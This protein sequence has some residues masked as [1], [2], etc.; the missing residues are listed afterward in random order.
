[1]KNES[2]QATLQLEEDWAQLELSP[3]DTVRCL[4]KWKN[5]TFTAN[6]AYGLVIVHPDVLVS[7]T[8]VADA[9]NCLRKSVLQDRVRATSSLSKALFYGSALHS[10]LQTG[11]ANDFSDKTLRAEID[12]Q[13]VSNM[14]KLYL[15][16]LSCEEASTYLHD[17]LSL[18]QQW[19]HKFHGQLGAVEPMR[20]KNKMLPVSVS[21][22]RALDIEERFW[23]PIYGLK[24]NIDVTAE[25]KL[26]IDG[27]LETIAAPLEFK[28][29]KTEYQQSSYRAQVMLYTLMM[30]ERYNVDVSAGYLYYLESGQIT[31]VPAA[32]N[33][34]R[35][36]LITRNEVAMHMKKK[37]LPPMIKNDF[38]CKNCYASEACFTYQKT[39]DPDFDLPHLGEKEIAFFRKWET[40]ITKEE[41]EMFRYRNEL[42]HMTAEEREKVN[43]CFAGLKVVPD[44]ETFNAG[45]DRMNQW[46]YQL[47]RKEHMLDSQIGEREPII[48]SDLEGRYAIS[49]GFVVKIQGNVI[50]VNV[51]RPL[52]DSRSRLP[53]FNLSNQLFRGQIP[54]VNDIV[55]RVD[56]DE[57]K[58]GM[59]IVRN[60]LISLLLPS[61]SRNASVSTERLRDLIVNLVEPKFSKPTTAP[62]RS[63]QIALNLDQTAAKEKVM[64]AKDY[65][66]ILGMP[67]TGKTTTIANIIKSLVDAGQ[68]VLLTS[69]THSAVDTIILKLLKHDI[70]ILRLGGLGKINPEVAKH[71][72]TEN[73]N[74][75]TFEEL[76][77]H[78]NS[79]N[80][81]ATTCLSINH[82]I[83]EKRRFDYCI[84]DEASQ[85]T[86]PVCIGPLRFADKFVLVGDHYQLPPLVKHTEAREGGLDVSLFKILC[87]AHPSA[88]TYLSHQYRM[89]QDIM[90]ISNTLIY[91][92]RLA[93]G[94]EELKNRRLKLDIGK[95]AQLHPKSC[96][97]C[98]VGLA[99]DP[100][101]PVMYLNTDSLNARESKN[102]DQIVNR[103]ESQLVSHLIQGLIACGVKDTDIGVISPYRSQL[104]V[105]QQDLKNPQILVDTAD[106]YQGRDK[107]CIIISLVRS[108][109]S[110]NVG[111]LIKDWR[112]MN[113]AFSRAKSKMLVIGSQNTLAN[114]PLLNAFLH[115]VH[116]NGWVCDLPS[117]A[118]GSHAFLSETTVKRETKHV[119]AGLQVIA[120]HRSILGDLINLNS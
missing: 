33:D 117:D 101:H 24:G 49:C 47:T 89:N 31:R 44:S 37:D 42:W 29:G 17:K 12:N 98:W 23:S 113:V 81:V 30:S 74:C 102:H 59:G 72:T 60:N 112:R 95:F 116:S 2:G 50:T 3:G 48:V 77:H 9:H 64:S 41:G 56:R 93:C 21:I 86:L 36:L 83:F 73:H 22:N 118:A 11:L 103:V 18:L 90:S 19:A 55:Y 106:K 119:T 82:A 65:A 35:G 39:Q 70:K 104:K 71:V 114:D 107:E 120:K 26:S 80:V 52:R 76:D 105:I 25:V 54:A 28:T 68:S 100:A 99:I 85:A 78:Y 75:K 6:N 53:E 67:G 79:P 115:Q 51:D 27:M 108:N 109:D 4:G 57:F 63:T 16:D 96:L 32:H 34:I 14:E 15:M 40:L 91:G 43:R 92:G 111:E 5:D 84:F 94:T 58:S 87:E 13:I 66:L 8:S 46:T 7:A 20:G 38:V 10:I 62:S 110:R 1:M 69:Y 61:T 97:S 88:I 45:A